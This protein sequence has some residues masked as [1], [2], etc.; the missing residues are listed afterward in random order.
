MTL[1]VTTSG[2]VVGAVAVI[3]VGWGVWLSIGSSRR[4]PG[5]AHSLLVGWRPLPWALAIVGVV[6]LVVVRPLWMGVAIIYIAMVSGYLMR[7]V[8]RSLDAVR[9]AYGEFDEIDR[10]PISGR[11]GGYLLAGAAMLG[12]LSLWDISVRGWNGV[13]GFAL[14][15]FLGGAGLVLR[16]AA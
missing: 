14:A 4:G 9:E 2:A 8:R 15:V 1:D 10:S 16:R 3:V 7:A 6:A 12:T 11:V 13:F 5:W